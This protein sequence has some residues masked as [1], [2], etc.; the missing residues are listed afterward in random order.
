[1]EGGG[2]VWSVVWVQVLVEGVLSPVMVG[3]KWNAAKQTRQLH[4]ALG[5][6]MAIGP[7]F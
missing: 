1:M 2:L 4:R 5:D 7:F 6:V 3:G